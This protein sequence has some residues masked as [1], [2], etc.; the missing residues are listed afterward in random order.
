MH[1]RRTMAAV[2][3]I[4]IENT[5]QDH[6]MPRREIERRLLEDYEISIRRKTFGLIIRDIQE[7]GFTVVYDPHRRGYYLERFFLD[8]GEIILLC[9]M[10]HCLGF[11]NIPESEQLIQKLMRLTSRYKN[12]ELRMNI[13]RSNERKTLHQNFI[14][15]VELLMN[16][17]AK[18]RKV[19]FDYYHYDFD[20]EL[21]QANTTMIIVEPRYITFA[22]SEFYLVVTGGKHPGLMHYRLDRI[23][24]LRMLDI[25]CSQFDY[26]EDAAGYAGNQ[27][28]MF[29]G[30]RISVTFLCEKRMLDYVIDQFGKEVPLYRTDDNHFEFTIRVTRIGAILFCSRF[31]DEMTI[32]FPED[33]RD[34]MHDRLVAA[35]NRHLL[36]ISEF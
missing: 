36:D 8:Q 23:E 4:L 27:L 5:D 3:I 31:L 26:T 6:C 17:I 12:N 24:N 7:F 29:S 18:N 35:A 10:I 13:F 11:I 33:L 34:E 14:I 22:N 16:A 21:H 9:S 30:E 25:P 28:F 20:K 1:D 32:I 19:T 2:V 15:Q